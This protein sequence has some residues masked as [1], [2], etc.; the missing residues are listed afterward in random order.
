MYLRASLLAATIL[1]AGCMTGDADPPPRTV[2]QDIG[3]CDAWMCGSNSPQIAEF[4]F[5]DLN[6]PLNAHTPGKANDA[7][8]SLVRFEK[9][10]GR[11]LPR[12]VKGKLIAQPIT[13][14][15]PFNV[16]LTGSS[17][18]GGALLL[19]TGARQFKI[20]VDATGTVKSWAQ[21]TDPAAPQVWLES[22]LLD[23]SEMAPD[24]SYERF[25]N[26]CSHP[27]ERDDTGMTGPLAFQTLLFEGD[28]ISATKKTIYDVD[29]TWFN[30]GCAGSAL[31]KMALTG[32][33]EAARQAQTFTTDP[34]QRQ[35]ILKMFAGDYCGDGTPFT[36]AG[37][38]LNWADDR[39]T[40]KMPAL[41]ASPPRPVVREARWTP[42]GA[43]CLDKAR[44]DAHWTLLGAQTFAAN[45]PV[46]DQVLARCPN[47]KPCDDNT[48]DVDGYHLITA[49]EPLAPPP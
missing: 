11:Y 9:G 38:P 37:Q 3:G 39:G 7:G 49:T 15:P 22:Y 47:L 43:A 10:A 42:D 19:R 41:L 34:L 44:V 21:P 5:W 36:V 1:G 2:Q 16:A 20:Q 6:T 4:G 26:M 33:T 35:T 18:V 29:T 31:A 30:L 23:W 12:V 17:L 25:V 46:I 24:G 27:G 45:G 14:L 28:R 32:H 48:L 13:S 8:L 40:M